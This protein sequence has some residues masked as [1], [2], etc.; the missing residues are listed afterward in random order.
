MNS[1]TNA[2]RT[3]T[4]EQI[5]KQLESPMW[6]I[7]SGTFDQEDLQPGDLVTGR[8]LPGM[9]ATRKDF[10]PAVLFLET[11]LPIL[12]VLDKPKQI[13]LWCYTV[14]YRGEI[15][16]VLPEYITHRLIETEGDKE[17]ESD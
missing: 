16:L 15:L 4:K 14:F 7:C 3:Y 17:K 5:E 10:G 11:E 12:L 8:A 1:P 6:E 9:I 13:G 2:D